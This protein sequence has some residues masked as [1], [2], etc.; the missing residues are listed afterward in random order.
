MGFL[1]KLMPGGGGILGLQKYISPSSEMMTGDMFGQ[2]MPA[3]MGDPS[4]SRALMGTSSGGLTPHEAMRPGPQ[5]TTNVSSGL[6]QMGG[7]GGGMAPPGGMGL[8]GM[9]L[10]FGMRQ[11]PAGLGRFGGY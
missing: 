4:I 2:M 10:P 3:G 8:P 5:N 6:P 9:G 11:P 7:Q 1:S